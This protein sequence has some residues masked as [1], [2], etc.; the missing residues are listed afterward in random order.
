MSLFPGIGVT[1]YRSFGRD[2]QMLAPLERINLVVGINDS[3]KSNFLSLFH[4]HG[5]VLRD[6]LAS[7][8]PSESFDARW[9]PHVVGDD[10]PPPIG[11]VWPLDTELAA[12]SHGRLDELI[13]HELFTRGTDWCWLPFRSDGPGQPFAVDYLWLNE[14]ATAIP[15][16]IWQQLSMD[17]TSQS[18]GGPLENHRRVV[19]FLARSLMSFPEVAF[20]PAHRRVLAGEAWDLS[21]S[22]LIDRLDTLKNAGA[23]ER[24]EKRAYADIRAGMADLLDVEAC[25]YNVPRTG[26]RVL[27]LI[28]DGAHRPLESFG[29]GYEHALLVVAATV[30]FPDRLLLIEEPEIHL[31]PRLQRRVAS[32]LSHR[33]HSQLIISTHSAVMIDE[34]RGHI[35]QTRKDPRTASTGVTSPVDSATV[36]MLDELGYRASD[37]LQANCII[38]VE[39]PS[40]RVYLNEW[41]RLYGQEVTHVAE[42]L[43]Y[44]IMSYGGSLLE[45]ATAASEGEDD[46]GRVPLRRLQQHFAIVADSD[47]SQPAHALKSRVLRATDEVAANPTAL[48]WI[49]AGRTVEN[50][51]PPTTLLNALRRAHPSVSENRFSGD[52]NEVALTPL[53]EDGAPL[54]AV[55][56]VAVA[57]AAVEAGLSLDVLDLRERITEMYG[58]IRVANE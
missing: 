46:R 26:D 28:V 54:K 56:K 36:T 47:K 8:K 40:D 39:G 38:W 50:Y 37:I 45:R 6:A 52:P 1:G 12:G 19:Q 34:L 58:F 13:S 41:L 3:G 48:M 27:E 20:I 55:D 17:L 22:G 7:G 30:A 44:S 21:G 16:E 24:Q 35:F 32:H 43:H 42:G 18:G 23:L 11:I 5:P 10:A 33:T 53:K 57:E 4:R 15:A 2:L 29:T 49:T 9:D 51:I 31:H 25:D 14:A